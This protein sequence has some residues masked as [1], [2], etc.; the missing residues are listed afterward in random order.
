MSLS[1][2]RSTASKPTT[3]SKPRGFLPVDVI[4]AHVEAGNGRPGHPLS[5]GLRER[6]IR[7]GV[8]MGAD[9]WLAA[10]EALIRGN[11]LHFQ[12][13]RAVISED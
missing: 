5:K 2:R 3:K 1:R 11:V 4:R 12:G 9:S 13:Q 8:I 10:L 6:G 7:M